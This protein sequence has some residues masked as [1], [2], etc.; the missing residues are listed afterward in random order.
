MATSSQAQ[1][2]SGP[3]TV[4]AVGVGHVHFPGFLNTLKHREDVKVKCVWDHD[5]ARGQHRAGELASAFVKDVG[6]I[7]KDPSIQAVLI[8]SETNRHRDLV[9]AAA[10]ARKHM[11]VEKPLGMGAE[12]ANEMADAMEKAKVLFTMGYAMRCTAASQFIKQQVEQ[13][14]W[15][16]S[17]ACAPPLA[18]TAR[19]AAGSTRSGVGWPT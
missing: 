11:F 2:K 13:A 7:W 8:C 3:I 19:W 6:E 4:A 10:Q 17:R 9:L 1:E 12:D 18:T 14:R 16:R 5:E 15:A